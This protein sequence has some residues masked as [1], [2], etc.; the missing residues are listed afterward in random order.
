MDADTPVPDDHAQWEAQ[1]LGHV[2]GGLKPDASSE[3]RRHLLGCSHCKAQVRE[4]RDLAGSLQIAARDEQ[5]MQAIRLAARADPE[6]EE[7][8]TP[9]PVTVSGRVLVIVVAT[10]VAIGLLVFSNMQQRQLAAS[11]SALATA[12]ASVITALGSGLVIDDVTMAGGASGVIVADEN[13]IAWSLSRLP[14]TTDTKWL[15]VWLVTDGAAEPVQVVRPGD[16]SP[17]ELTGTV[18]DDEADTLVVTMTLNNDLESP[19]TGVDPPGAQQ[20]LADLSQVRAG[21]N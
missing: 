20:V 12:Q 4:L 2:M 10:V 9:E 15:V 8:S 6:R 1:A 14:H 21:K 7:R 11:S 3:F 13:T 5:S 18:P 19:V 16:Q 17:G